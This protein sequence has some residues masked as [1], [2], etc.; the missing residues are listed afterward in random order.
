MG[1]NTFISTPSSPSAVCFELS[2]THFWAVLCT[3]S[4]T[5]RSTGDIQQINMTDIARGIWAL[6]SVALPIQL[7][8]FRTSSGPGIPEVSGFVWTKTQRSLMVPKE[9][10][11][12]SSALQLKTH[13]CKGLFGY[14]S[15]L[16]ALT[17][18]QQKKNAFVFLFCFF[19]I[20]SNAKIVPWT[21]TSWKILTN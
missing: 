9:G 20:Q 1:I 3:M 16:T 2:S 18:S 10:E 14:N 13:P 11:S 19:Y 8:G 4:G 7:Q 6:V 17:K 21:L 15:F 5:T 12:C